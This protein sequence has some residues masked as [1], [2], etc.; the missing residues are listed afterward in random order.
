MNTVI[1]NSAAAR[2]SLPAGRL[3]I[4]AAAAALLLLASLRVL[5]REF[6]PSW[7]MVA[8][9]ASADVVLL[10]APDQKSADA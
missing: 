3:A 1:S 10:L 9:R 6:D 7:R 4:T 2:L 8:A 5:S